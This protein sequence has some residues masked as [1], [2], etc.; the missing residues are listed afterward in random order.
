MLFCSI[1]PL[2]R[3][4]TVS[5]RCRYKINSTRFYWTTIIAADLTKS[6]QTFNRYTQ[7]DLI[8]ALLKLTG[9]QTDHTSCQKCHSHQ[10]NLI[11][12]LVT[13]VTCWTQQYIVQEIGNT[14]PVCIYLRHLS[15]V[16]QGS[17]CVMVAKGSFPC[18]T[19]L[20]PPFLSFTSSPV[21]YRRAGSLTAL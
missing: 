4:Q 20:I 11:A 9:P 1:K 10:C 8:L 6:Y 13:Q 15:R 7:N 16:H 19:P 21:P 18:P 17:I 3:S 2:E 5:Y 12:T 14:V